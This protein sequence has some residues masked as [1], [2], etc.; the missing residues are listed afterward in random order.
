[1]H[2][3]L[4]SMVSSFAANLCICLHRSLSTENQRD[5]RLGCMQEK[6]KSSFGQGIHQP[7]GLCFSLQYSK[8][9][10][11]NCSPLPPSKSL[12]TEDHCVESLKLIVYKPIHLKI[13]KCPKIL[14]MFFICALQDYLNLCY[15]ANK[16]TFINNIL[17]RII[18]Y[19]EVSVAF[20]AIIRAA[21]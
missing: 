15:K 10:V 5:S 12:L 11:G 13:L 20:A 18:N 1:M 3:L 17:S 9:T 4:K 7:Q 19:Q 14:Y 2:L 16:C 8:H 6:C 21:L